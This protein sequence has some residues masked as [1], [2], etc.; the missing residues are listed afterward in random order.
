MSGLDALRAEGLSPPSDSDGAPG[1]VVLSARIAPYV[2]DLFRWNKNS[3]GT[4][5]V[6]KEIQA[7]VRASVTVHVVQISR[8][9]QSPWPELDKE[10][11]AFKRYGPE[12]C[13]GGNSGPAEWFG[14]KTSFAIRLQVDNKGSFLFSL[15]HP[16]LGASSRLTRCYGSSWLIKL[17]LSQDV[18]S[19]LDKLKGLLLQP[20]VLN[21]QVFRFFYMNKDNVAYLMATNEHYDG[22]LHLSQKG[23]RR[24]CDIL[25]FFSTHNKLQENSNQTIAKWGSRIALGLS[26]SIPGLTLENSQIKEEVDIISSSC[27]PGVKHTSEMNMTD[28]CGLMNHQAIYMLHEKLGV[29]KEIPVAIQCRLAGAKGLLL[30]HP[31]K[32]ENIWPYPCVW[33][34]PSQMKIQPSQTYMEITAHRIID[35]LRASH[36]QVSVP[37]SREIIVNLSENGVSPNI[38]IDLFSQSI[39]DTIS[40]F[41][42]WDG[43]DAMLQLWATVFKEGKIMATRIARE[44]S[45]TA[46]A[47][48][49]QLYDQEDNNEDTEA[50]DDND[51]SHSK[52]WWGDATSGCPSS[53]EET[54]LTFLDTGFSP[55]S[56][57]MLAAKL[58]IVAKKVVTS[59]LS[60]YRITIPMS[61]SAFIVPDVLGVLNEG[62]IH[63]KSS[64]RHFLRPDGQKSDR[65]IGDVLVTRSPCKLP[66]DVQKVKAVFKPELDDYVDVIMF[67]IKGSRSLASMLGTGDYDGDIVVCIWQPSIVEMFSNADPKHMEPP[68]DLEDHFDIKNETVKEFL[69]R[70]PQTSPTSHQIQ[71]LQMVLMA[72]LSDLYVVGTYSTMHDN[73]IYTLGYTHPTTTLLAW[74]FCTVLD[75]AKTGKTISRE[76]YRRDRNN[77]L[78]G[79]QFAPRWKTT[80]TTTAAAAAAAMA[81][82]DPDQRG[83]R[84][85]PSREEGMPPFVMDVLQEAMRAVADEQLRRL[86]GRFDALPKVKDAA[87]VAPWQEAEARAQEMLSRPEEHV[88]HVGRAQQD[89]LDAIKTHVSRVYE[90]S[91]SVMKG[92]S[93]AQQQQ[94]QQQQRRRSRRPQQHQGGAEFTRR[95]IET[96]QD[97]LRRISREFVGG[98]PASDTFAYSQEEV[99]RLRASYAY[100]HDWTKKFGGTRFPWNVAM[101][102][103]GAIKLRARK[104]F[105]PISQDF[106]EKMSMRRL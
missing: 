36:M 98:P 78:Y 79:T 75:G 40:T 15:E 92:T 105:K 97:Q 46:R 85:N 66:T 50:D 35:V 22:N 88:R 60:N 43:K 106:Y 23:N 103:L 104:D 1:Q 12:G 5:R 37:I 21:G 29:W 52:A 62:E 65:V 33:L 6:T 102:E 67:S 27:P 39:D 87:L 28:G 70:V 10:D 48:G 99:A 13:L 72:P 42:N 58:H 18:Y 94:Q 4:Q 76:R 90:L 25:K 96:R 9:L 30:L 80:M 16:V 34:R 8:C 89:A 17:Q 24:Y 101:R 20:L 82:S 77:K 63:V 83:H 45:W 47:R 95:S 57:S 53:L 84:F 71:E 61:C 38:F 51:S 26:N 2:E 56:N 32:E 59:C 31:G 49:F 73:A 69:E 93:A 44:S 68:S 41:L 86:A 64:K 54:V 81:M 55:A 14:G 100:L 3:F 91:V 7:T 74:I 19:Q 11:A